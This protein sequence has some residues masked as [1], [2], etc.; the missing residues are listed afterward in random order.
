MGDRSQGPYQPLQDEGSTEDRFRLLSLAPG[1]YDD[2]IQITLTTHDIQLAPNATKRALRSIKSHLEI[3][4]REL[5][6]TGCVQADGSR[7]ELRFLRNLDESFK[8]WESLESFRTRQE[9]LEFVK[10]ALGE[11]MLLDRNRLRLNQCIVHA[12]CGLVEHVKRFMDSKIDFEALSYTWGTT[13]AADTVIVNGWPLEITQN[14]DLALRHLR[15]PAQT[16]IMWV[17]ALC[18]NQQDIDERNYQVPLMGSIYA[19]AS[20]TTVWLGPASDESDLVMEVIRTS[21]MHGMNP[22]CLCIDIL[23]LMTRSWWTRVWV[24]QEVALAQRVV[25]QCGM[26]SIPRVDFLAGLERASTWCE[27]TKLKNQSE[28]DDAVRKLSYSTDVL[29]FLPKMLVESAISDFDNHVG[30]DSGEASIYEH[31]AGFWC[32]LPSRQ[33]MVL[34]VQGCRMP[35]SELWDMSRYFLATNPRDKVYALLSMA[36]F[37][38]RPI[39]PDYRNPVVSVLSEAFALVISEELSTAYCTSPLR[40]KIAL[41]PDLPSWVPDLSSSFSPDAPMEDVLWSGGDPGACC[42]A[43]GLIDAAYSRLAGTSGSIMH[44]AQTTFSFDFKELKTVGTKHGTIIK[45]ITFFS[46]AVTGKDEASLTVKQLVAMRQQ[47]HSEPPSSP[48]LLSALCG[49]PGMPFQ[50][51]ES[52]YGLIKALADPAW[53]D[54]VTIERDYTPALGSLLQI[55]D[56]RTIFL[57][58]TGYIGRSQGDI[59]EGDVLA[60]LFG[61]DLPFVLRPKDGGKYAMINTAHVA[62]HLLSPPWRDRDQRF[63]KRKRQRT[64]REEKFTIV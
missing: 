61:I 2:P 57:T 64:R 5:E 42:P 4:G 20:Q 30:Y 55:L 15:Q 46:P 37:F 40:R 17:D 14:L 25:I 38:G 36:S 18:I 8:L 31:L 28:V 34:K 7:A 10:E 59:K 23:R 54:R 29:K 32:T 24:I 52:A 9:A 60:G 63:R 44:S 45:S 19:G 12:F 62:D 27:E 51:E 56:K 35:F 41:I 33:S 47:F 53:L 21:K 13:K 58:D 39:H 16:K 1:S 6:R 43:R 49:I 22:F 3:I 26:Q 11:L 50:P 48:K